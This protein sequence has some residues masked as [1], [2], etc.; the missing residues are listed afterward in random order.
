MLHSKM[1]TSDQHQ[2]YKG[3]IRVCKKAQRW[4]RRVL[5]LCLWA[6][7]TKMNFYLSNGKAKIWRKKWNCKRSQAYSL[8]YGGGGVMAWACM[9][10]S[11]TGPL[12]FTDD[13]MFDDS[14]R[15]NLEGYKT[16]L[17]TNIQENA[18]QIHWEVLYIASGQ[19]PKPPYQVSQE[20]YK[21]KEI[22]S[23]TVHSHQMQLVRI[24]CAIR[25]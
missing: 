4:A 19:W 24:N 3:K 18:N 16:I 22:E 9:A 10:V 14:S 8:V 2:N 12:K 7:E 1:Q 17:P 13:L 5:E 23:L 6:D 15:I 20:I 11:G 25:A 21:G